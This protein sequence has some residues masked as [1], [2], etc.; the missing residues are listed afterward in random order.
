[1]QFAVSE[2]L[3]VVLRLE[4]PELASLPWEYMFDQS[5][6]VDVDGSYLCLRDSSPLVRHLYAQHPRKV[7]P[8]GNKLRILGMV[9][10]PATE[11]W[12]PLDV[13]AERTRIERALKI[14]RPEVE[15]K[16]VLGGRWDDLF[17][18]VQA[19]SFDVFHF[20]GHGG[21]AETTDANGKKSQ[22]GYLVMQDGRG[23]AVPVS[24][25]TMAMTL[26]SAPEI[27]LAVLNCCES[28]RG[29]S[30]FLS[31]GAALVSNSTPMVVAMQY[32]ITDDSAARFAGAFYSSI[33]GGQ[34]VERALTSARKYM[35]FES[36]VE[37]GI[38]V[39]FT[40]T[41]PAPLLELDVQPVPRAK[42]TNTVADAPAP[43]TQRE[44]AL[45]ELRRLFQ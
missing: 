20:I 27:Q 16:W 37:W 13:E 23:G 35:R 11:E 6:K 30:Q 43:P 45:A 2:G 8:V 1:M 31:L 26:D 38:P 44:E 36:N 39:F 17:E 33:V 25:S 15:L 42:K 18:M 7:R 41:S 19:E 29:S 9:A 24:A 21:T 4:P 5:T 12:R 40:Q 14:P 10:N 32:A 3:R 22:E 28:G 34:C